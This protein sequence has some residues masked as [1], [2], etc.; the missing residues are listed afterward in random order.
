M[1]AAE[2]PTATSTSSYFDPTWS[3]TNENEAALGPRSI[4]GF[5]A[6]L[7]GRTTLSSNS[8]GNTAGR[9]FVAA[10]EHNDDFAKGS[11]HV[12]LA[13]S[14]F[15]QLFPSSFSPEPLLCLS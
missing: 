3:K 12:S 8:L 1:Q 5:P 10:Q 9:T 11:F 15:F 4:D 6:D 13:F 7:S 2:G 14:P